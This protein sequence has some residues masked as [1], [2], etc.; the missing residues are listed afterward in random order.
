VGAAAATGHVGLGGWWLFA[1]VMV[2]TPAHFWALALLLREDY[3]AVGIPMLPVVKGP[4]VTARAI[5]TYGWITVLLSGLGVF[6]L[7]SGGAFYG[8][9]LLPYNGRLLQL[10]DRL[11][12]DPDSLVNAKALF[13]WSILYLFGLCLLLILS[14]TDLASGFAQQVM[15]LLPLPT[16]VQ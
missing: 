9:M 1:L 6:A 8:V 11:S 3:R 13:R 2:W 5:K 15:Q 14:R 4:V 12:L 7:P 16:G 10:V